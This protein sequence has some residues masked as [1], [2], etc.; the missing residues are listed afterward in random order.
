[1]NNLKFGNAVVVQDSTELTGVYL[2]FGRTL[3]DLRNKTIS[4]LNNLE[5]VHIRQDQVR[6]ATEL[7]ER[8]GKRL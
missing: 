1:M 3:Y 5:I 4:I 7:E 6:F 8:L 2:V